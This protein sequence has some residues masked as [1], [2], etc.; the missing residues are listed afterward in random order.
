MQALGFDLSSL[1]A[2]TDTEEKPREPESGIYFKNTIFNEH[3]V[4]HRYRD[5][6][7]PDRHTSKQR[8][9]RKTN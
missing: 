1:C 9:Y 6:D 4:V 7:R 8:M 5:A 3:P 2:D